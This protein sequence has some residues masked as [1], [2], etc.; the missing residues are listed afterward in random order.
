MMLVEVRIN[1]TSVIKIMSEETLPN[2]ELPV[3]P[4]NGVAASPDVAPETPEN[5]K[6]TPTPVE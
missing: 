1:I 4:E 2:Q 6:S 5:G 3:N